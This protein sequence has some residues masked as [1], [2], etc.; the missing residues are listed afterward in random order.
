MYRLSIGSSELSCFDIVVISVM[1][2]QVEVVD[3][4]SQLGGESEKR[5]CSH[6]ALEVIGYAYRLEDCM[7]DAEGMTS[8]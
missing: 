7:R 5:R 3:H 6:G 8:R 2:T 4:E 1:K